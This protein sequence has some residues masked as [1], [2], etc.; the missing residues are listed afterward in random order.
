MF[1]AAA[2]TPPRNPA[3]THPP[4]RPAA[5]TPPRNPSATHP[6]RRPA[7]KTPPR[8]P[9]ATH[10]PRR[11]AAKT[12]PVSTLKTL[13]RVIHFDTPQ[14]AANNHRWHNHRRN[15]TRFQALRPLTLAVRTQAPKRAVIYAIRALNKTFHIQTTTRDHFATFSQF[16]GSNRRFKAPTGVLAARRGAD[17]LGPCVCRGG[18]K[19]GRV[20]KGAGRGG[21]GRE[22][23]GREV[24]RVVVIVIGGGG[25]VGDGGGGV[26]EAGVA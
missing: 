7:A 20:E 21:A 13:N 15:K 3:A 17:G 1:T 4:R 25:G 14:S 12:P 16:R 11:P 23:A 5:K 24:A 22:V 6:P 18:L 2:K 19:K 8:N 9:S 26:G 10:P